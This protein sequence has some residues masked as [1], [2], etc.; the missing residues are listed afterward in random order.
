[1]HYQK[2]SIN[3][4]GPYE[5]EVS[6]DFENGLT[7]IIG[8]NGSGK[9][10]I[11]DAI[12]WAMFGPA[13]SVRAGGD[14]MSIIN[15]HAHKSVVELSLELD[16]KTQITINRTL[17]R[18]SK[19][20]LKV[21]I[22]GEEID[23]GITV[24]QEKINSL[25]TG[26]EH[27]SFAAVS[28][29]MSSPSSVVNEFITGDPKRR[30]VIL[31]DIVDPNHMYEQRHKE[32]K[33]QITKAN[34]NHQTLIG[35]K[36]TLDGILESKVAPEYPEDDV[37]KLQI[38]LDNIISKINEINRSSEGT[39]LVIARR[40]YENKIAKIEKKKEKAEKSIHKDEKFIEKFT[41]KKSSLEKR[42]E[43][44]Y[45]KKDTVEEDLEYRKAELDAASYIYK[46]YKDV[47]SS[48]NDNI[49][50][51]DK[52]IT[53]QNTL[54]SLWD[55]DRKTCAVCGADIDENSH[56]YH[57]D[58]LNYIDELEKIK[59][60]IKDVIKEYREKANI[61]QENINIDTAE[62]AALESA[63]SL[64][65]IIE[66][67]ENSLDDISADLD[68][69]QQSIKKNKKY[70]DVSY[71]EEK[72]NVLEKMD[73]IPHTKDSEELEKLEKRRDILVSK[74][75]NT[76]IKQ[77]R[78]QA[79]EEDIKDLQD[80][81]EE[82]EE[83]IE[84][85]E[86]R[87]QELQQEKQDTSP[88]GLISKDIDEISQMITTNANDMYERLFDTIG[89]DILIKSYKESNSGEEEPTCVITMGG[90][91]LSSYSHGE[92]SRAISAILL[93]FVQ[94]VYDYSGQWYVPL[95]DEPTVTI[96]NS[97]TEVFFSRIGEIIEETEQQAI[98][99]TR[100]D[101]HPKNANIIDLVK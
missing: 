71:D 57:N 88:T 73:D 31:S 45:D 14:K 10:S 42:L 33:E 93:G 64:E 29:L 18:G 1:M 44:L 13:K 52:K 46:G 30:R 41:D 90:R 39:S 86:D 43:D 35:D 6:F 99:I 89:S 7:L 25:L 9:S 98:I 70:I 59:N 100:D 87:L 68:D 3:G 92:Q 82:A 81:I 72:N 19:H 62:I 84:N 77:S 65:T 4:F 5:E 91:S 75:N 78:Y 20:M 94:S 85:S 32:V 96:D 22:N 34:K 101:I 21:S 28:M 79:Y 74:I 58:T 36:R 40:E 48:Y 26:L 47:I 83:A 16:D 54:S 15:T 63:E 50:N 37:K 95:W 67:I 11:F 24:Q 60:N 38:K 61:A 97:A 17:T 80:R 69:A 12:Q 27:D 2:I 51:V 56:K 8:K 55:D 76:K 53:Q 49:D 23:G 66:D